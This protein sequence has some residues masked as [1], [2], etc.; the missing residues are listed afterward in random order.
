MQAIFLKRIRILIHSDPAGFAHGSVTFSEFAQI[1]KK[2]K[3]ILYESKF[4]IKIT[5][6][7]Y[8]MAEKDDIIELLIRSLE[9]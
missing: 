8:T 3:I 2:M 6:K 1:S 4:W 9:L 5:K 7:K